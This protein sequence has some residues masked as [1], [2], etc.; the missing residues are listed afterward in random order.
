MKYF[1]TVVSYIFHPFLM[2]LLGLFVMFE[3]P[4]LPNSYNIYDALYFYPDQAKH[5]LYIVLGI[6]TFLAPLFSLL[7]MYWNKMVNSLELEDRK[8]RIYPFVLVTFY[9]ILAYVYLRMQ[10]PD[11]LQ[12]PA[13]MSFILGIIFTFI[14]AFV[15]NLF[16]KISMHAA[17]AFGVCGMLLAYHQS[18]IESNLA[19][20][21][22][23]ICIASLVAGARVYLKAHTLKETLWGMFV[24]F[25]VL[26]T[27][28]KTGIYLDI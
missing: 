27:T 25:T 5:V 20:L 26:Y 10:L 23:L 16:M 7:I 12:H 11:F 14:I 9:F 19:F 4:T 13:L 15:F 17:G 6:L 2:P 24:G 21:L 28:V 8:E 18:Q 1:F 3:S 22:Y